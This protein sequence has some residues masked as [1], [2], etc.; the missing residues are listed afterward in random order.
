MIQLKDGTWMKSRDYLEEETDLKIESRDLN[1]TIC[2]GYALMWI[3]YPSIRE[4]IKRTIKKSIIHLKEK[5]RAEVRRKEREDK[6][7]DTF[8]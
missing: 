1:S 8:I 7:C 4:E 3:N 2:D 5:R 6:K